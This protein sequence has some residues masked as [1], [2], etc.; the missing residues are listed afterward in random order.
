MNFHYD[1]PKKFSHMWPCSARGRNVCFLF[2]WLVN[3]DKRLKAEVIW[4]C[5]L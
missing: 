1:K 3:E 4:V 2:V 5:A